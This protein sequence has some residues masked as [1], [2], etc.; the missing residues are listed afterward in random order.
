[1]TSKHSVKVLDYFHLEFLYRN[2]TQFRIKHEA[3]VLIFPAN[4]AILFAPILRDQR[5]NVAQ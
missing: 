3:F 2:N 4:F 5:S 1:M